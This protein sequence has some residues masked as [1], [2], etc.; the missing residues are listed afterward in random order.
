[1]TIIIV[2]FITKE[3]KE[4]LDE[5]LLNLKKAKLYIQDKAADSYDNIINHIDIK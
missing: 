5:L 2:Y 4:L 1:M 3:H